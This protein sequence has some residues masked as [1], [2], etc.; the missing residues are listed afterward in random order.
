MI[1][2]DGFFQIKQAF[3]EALH[4]DKDIGRLLKNERHLFAA[5]WHVGFKKMMLRIV[6]KSWHQFFHGPSNIALITGKK[7]QRQSR[8]LFVIK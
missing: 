5:N 2:F 1:V 6:Q 3:T 4:P 7:S 8:V